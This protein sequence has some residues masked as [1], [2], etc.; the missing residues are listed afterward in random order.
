MRR[1][2]LFALLGAFGC[3]DD[4]GG[5]TVSVLAPNAPDAVIAY[6]DGDGPWLTSLGTQA[7]ISFSVTS[8]RY[9]VAVACGLKRRV[10]VYELMLNDLQTL[11]YVHEC[12]MRPLTL[13]VNTSGNG[14]NGNW[15]QWGLDASGYA[16]V[17]TPT[18]SYSLGVAAGLH[19]LGVTRGVYPDRLVIV[20]GLQVSANQTVDVDFEA[21]TAIPLEVRSIQAPTTLAVTYVTKGGTPINLG[22]S[23][24]AAAVPSGPLPAGDLLVFATGGDQTPGGSTFSDARLATRDI[25]TMVRGAVVPSQAPTVTNSIAGTYATPLAQWVVQPDTQLYRFAVADNQNGWEIYASSATFEAAPTLTVPDLSGV[26]G[27]DATLG[28]AAGTLAWEVRYYSGTSLAE[29]IRPY[30]SQEGEIRSGGWTGEVP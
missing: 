18:S 30:P 10:R 29:L 8:G 27:W 5:T 28:L 4:G 6:R 12:R 13:T 24:D 15:L 25:P 7:P 2:S 11:E 9:T 19:D 1:Y 21:A 22:I 16:T 20:P 17:S 23:T 26:T 14:T 3:S